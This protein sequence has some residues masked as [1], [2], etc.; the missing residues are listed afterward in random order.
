MLCKIHA[1]IPGN[2]ILIPTQNSGHPNTILVP[3]FKCCA[4]SM[5]PYDIAIQSVTCKPSLIYAI[6]HRRFLYPYDE[7]LIQL[8]FK[9]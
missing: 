7:T 4:K 5:L 3:A 2:H 1:Q 9:K 8:N 6:Q